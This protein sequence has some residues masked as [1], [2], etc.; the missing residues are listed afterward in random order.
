[1][2]ISKVK[3]IEDFLDKLE[4]IKPSFDY[5]D[6]KNQKVILKRI[7]LLSK[8][9]RSKQNLQQL[10][11]QRSILYIGCEEYRKAL[12]DLNRLITLDP[13]KRIKFGV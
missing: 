2:V 4:S 5:H 1:M 7:A 13:R 6:V 12:K 10:Y 11:F 9:I 3:K 8:K